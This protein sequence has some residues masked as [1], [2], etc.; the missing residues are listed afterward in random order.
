MTNNDVLKRMRYTLDLDDTKM[1][2]LFSHTGVEVTRAE[3]SNW[4]KKE[5]DEDYVDLLDIELSTFLNGLII[6]KR[7]RREGPAPIPEDYLT[8]NNIIR[9]VKIAFDFK[10]DDILE[11]Y[12]LI[13]KNLSKSE[14]GAFLRNPNHAKY[15]ECNDQYLRHFLSGLQT[16]FRPK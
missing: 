2:E 11:L 3:V 13:G 9:K 10:T 14:L 5:E 15:K 1:I 6:E 7:G 8:N 12:T 4:L 16:K